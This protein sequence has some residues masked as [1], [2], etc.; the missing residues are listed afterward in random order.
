MHLKVK[1]HKIILSFCPTDYVLSSVIRQINSFMDKY[2]EWCF[3]NC[4]V[5]NPIKSNYVSFFA[6]A[7]YVKIDNQ[8]LH[9]PDF[10]KYLGLHID[11]KLN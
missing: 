9:K 4:I 6:D 1:F 11:K 10:V 2:C 8:N 7:A 3:Q 5:I